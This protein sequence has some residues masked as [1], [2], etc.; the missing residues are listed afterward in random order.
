M[1]SD[2]YVCLFQIQA[3]NFTRKKAKYEYLKSAIMVSCVKWEVFELYKLKNGGA[4]LPA[5]VARR[6]SRGD[7]AARK[8]QVN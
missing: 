1:T 6:N 8:M 7:S 5:S 2:V 4:T 3:N